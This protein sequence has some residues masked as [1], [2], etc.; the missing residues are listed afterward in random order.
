MS[1]VDPL[2][3]YFGGLASVLRSARRSFSGTIPYLFGFGESR[4]EVTEFYP[5][6]VSSRTEDDLPP[7]TRGFLIN[8]IEKCT[9]CGDC[10]TVCP[11]RCIDLVTEP[12]PDPKRL[13]VSV[14]DIHR[15][16]CVLCGLCVDV[17]KPRSLSHTRRFE[18]A[19][20]RLE[21]LKSSFGRGNVSDEQRARWTRVLNQS[22]EV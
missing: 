6:P 7:R 2:R 3:E 14:F 15:G 11:V 4:K 5:D 18:G 13:W 19:V 12:G 16:R 8:E 9:G 1:F 22:G 17:C 21:D 10:V 20:Q